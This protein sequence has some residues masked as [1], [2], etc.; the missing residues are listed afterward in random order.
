MTVNVIFTLS[1]TVYT[2]TEEKC[3]YGNVQSGSQACPLLLCLV[4]NLVPNKPFLLNVVLFYYTTC[5][6][7]ICC[8]WRVIFIIRV[9][10]LHIM[11]FAHSQNNA[12]TTRECIRIYYMQLCNMY[13]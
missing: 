8:S 13:T 6:S 5:T 1:G 10:T 9:V 12:Y 2:L 11:Q 4:N 3:G 7:E